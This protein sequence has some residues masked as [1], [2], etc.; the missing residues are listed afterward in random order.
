M[1][2]ICS[3]LLVVGHVLWQQGDGPTIQPINDQDHMLLWNGDVYDDRENMSESDTEY[4]L[5][6]IKACETEDDLFQLLETVNGPY[7]IIYFD[8][9]SQRLYFGRDMFGRHSLLL[10]K[11]EPDER[12]QSN[13]DDIV[14]SSVLGKFTVFKFMKVFDS[15]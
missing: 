10:G 4:M 1:Q 2:C 12:R 8:A 6:R 11:C 13:S 15:T 14:I 9:K 5:N 7:S 3:Q